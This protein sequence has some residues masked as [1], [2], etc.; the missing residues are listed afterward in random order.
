MLAY[1]DMNKPF[2]L[3]CDAYNSAI[4]FVFGQIVRKNESIIACR[5]KSLSKTEQSLNTSEKEC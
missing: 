4:S 2:M 3:T 1:R 5:G